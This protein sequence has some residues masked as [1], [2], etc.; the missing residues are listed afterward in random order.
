LPAMG[1]FSLPADFRPETIAELARANAAL[2][3]PVREVY[4][5]LNPSPYGSGRRPGLL[6][7]VTPEELS[8][9]IASAAAVGIEFNYALNF[10][11]LGNREYAERAQLR[12]FVED[13]VGLG[14][15]RFTVALPTVLDVFAD[16][17]GVRVTISTILAVQSP[18]A[19]RFLEQFPWVDR[20]CV[21]E[22]LNRDLPKLA[23][24]CRMARLEISTVVNSFC[25]LWCPFRA[26]HYDYESHAPEAQHDYL[27]RVCDSVRRRDPAAILSSPWIRPEELDR[28]IALGVSLFKFSGREMPNPAFLRSVL[29]YNE[30]RY[31]GD[32]IDLLAGFSAARRMYAIRLE[33]RALDRIMDRILAR[34]SG[35]HPLYCGRCGICSSPEAASA[36]SPAPSG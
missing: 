13:L 36:W 10:S 8:R 3:L 16:L 26:P 2:S 19:V 27:G 1:S 35:C 24:L 6:M 34:R 33:N 5:S 32:L 14:V 20:L 17:P 9:Y 21:P 4:G 7:P 25:L 23:R 22:S 11:S 28:Y 29:V 30:R 31:E 15:R 18:V 12:R